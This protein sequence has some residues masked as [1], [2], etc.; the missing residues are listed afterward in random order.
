MH[1]HNTAIVVGAGIVGLATAKALVN[2]GFKVT[3]IEKNEKAVGASIR[4]FGMIWPIGQPSGELFNRACRTKEIWKEIAND[5]HIWYDECGSIHLAY[6]QQELN[7]LEELAA[8]FQTEKRDIQ[9]FNHAQIS[10]RFKG[11]QT[12]GL[13]GGL[14]SS[15][16]MIVNPV[17][18]IPAVAAYLQEQKKVNFIWGQTVTS[19]ENGKIFIGK[20]SMEADLIFICSGAEFE[21]LFPD[22]FALAP[23][24]KCK[25]QMLRYSLRRPA[26]RI[27]TSVCGGLSLLHYQSFKVAKGLDTLKTMYENEYPE[28]LNHGIHVMLSQNDKGEVTIGDSHEYGKSF[29]PF[30][31]A[32][33]NEWIIT[34]AEKMFPL[35]QYNLTE[36]WNGIYLKMLNGESHLFT[37]PFGNTYI[38]NALGGAGMTLSFGLAE[39]LVNSLC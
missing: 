27:G 25:L 37:N 21:N 36:T 1:F 20:E 11:I 5:C 35:T 8:I 6:H 32:Y 31:K 30:D 10:N 3:I 16:E 4:N 2:R 26:E 13:L 14:Y 29:E 38:I 34:Y 18:A 24:T 39:E 17:K 23:I 15:S 9:L 22:L 33:I 19:V 28:Y 7:V 12:M